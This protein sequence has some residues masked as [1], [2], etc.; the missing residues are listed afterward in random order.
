MIF[1]ALADYKSHGNDKCKNLRNRHC[2]P[3]SVYAENDWQYQNAN[4]LEKQC[5]Q[6]EMRA[7]TVPLLSAVKNAE[8]K[9]LNP[10]SKNEQEKILKARTVSS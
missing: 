4:A 2:P 9:I 3:N 8:A 7:E 5:A 6:N 10:A 1:F